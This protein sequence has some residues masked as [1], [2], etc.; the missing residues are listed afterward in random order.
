MHITIVNS[1]DWSAI[2]VNRKLKTQGHCVRY[3][4]LLDIIQKEGE[5]L[6]SW[7]D[8]YLINDEWV[9]SGIGF[10]EDIKDLP[11]NKQ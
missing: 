5:I 3:D 10:P 8:I 7:M 4:E 11:E 6:E 2:Y 9:E 1:D